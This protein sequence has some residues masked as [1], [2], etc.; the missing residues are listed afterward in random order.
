MA[1]GIADRVQLSDVVHRYAAAVDDR[2]FPD[3]ADLFTDT[4]ELALPNPPDHLDPVHHFAGPEGVLAA[5]AALQAVPRTEHAIVGEVYGDADAP[6]RAV[7]RIACV[8]HHWS[9]QDGQLTD[10]VWHMRYD[11]VYRV[12]G[13]GW[14]IE[15]RALTINAIETRPLRRLR[16]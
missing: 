14:Q 15:R 3:A 16:S 12:T 13:R 9:A 5:L 6:D 11:D 8:A 4:A 7:G 10:V 1:L 2:R